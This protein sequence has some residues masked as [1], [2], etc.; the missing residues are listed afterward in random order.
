MLSRYSVRLIVINYSLASQN[1]KFCLTVIISKPFSMSTDS[2]II[3]RQ[4]F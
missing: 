2:S 4:T 3:I 1:M